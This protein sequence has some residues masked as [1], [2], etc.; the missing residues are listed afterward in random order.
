MCVCVCV[1][2]RARAC[3]L[4]CVQEPV[5]IHAKGKGVMKC[6]WVNDLSD[7]WRGIALRF[8]SQANV[9]GGSG[10]GIGQPSG[11]DFTSSAPDEVAGEVADEASARD[12]DVEIEIA[13]DHEESPQWSREKDGASIVTWK[14]LQPPLGITSTEECSN[15]GATGSNGDPNNARA[16]D[17][18]RGPPTLH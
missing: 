6:Y 18:A 12:V 11:N 7:P 16:G 3:V 17:A 2:A 14:A 5:T 10:T 15:G 1:C 8:G 4:M 9:L 13:N